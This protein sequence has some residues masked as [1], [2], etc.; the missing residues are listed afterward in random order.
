MLSILFL[1]AVSAAMGQTAGFSVG[2]IQARGGEAASGMLSVL[3][4]MDGDAEIPVTILRGSRP[5]PTLALVAGN[6]G[7]EYTPVLASQRLRATLDPKRLAGTVILVHLANPP[8]FFARTIYFSPVDRKNLNRVY[9][10]KRDGTLSERIAYAITREIIEKSDYLVDLHCGDGNEWLRPY[11][12]QAVTGDKKMDDAIAAMA[13]AFGLE[14]IVLDEGR[15]KDSAAS[16][17]C[18]TTAITRGKPALTVESGYLGNTDEESIGRLTSGVE[19]LLRHLRMMEGEVKRLDHPVYLSPA[20]VVPSPETGVL[21]PKAGRDQTVRKG[22]L[23]AE[24]R[25]LFGRPLAEVRSP[26]DGIV[27]YIVATPPI[28][29]DQPV[30]F[31]GAVRK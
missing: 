21:F 24:I 11:S 6:H 16:V 27:L 30:A 14:Y 23:L 5:G 7:Y 31:V 28:V 18:S 19:N 9:P 3:S 4:G 20:L 12:Y 26:L 2:S 17:Y 10:G 1:L 13:L 15:P 29:K 22:A 25:D 8:S